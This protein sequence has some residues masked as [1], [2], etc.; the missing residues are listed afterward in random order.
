M[1]TAVAAFKFN[2]SRDIT[3]NPSTAGCYP[4]PA[5]QLSRT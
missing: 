2:G 1:L 3:E 5:A 4:S